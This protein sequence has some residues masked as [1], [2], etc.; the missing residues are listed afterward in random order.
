MLNKRAHTMNV[1]SLCS[2][3][4]R[5]PAILALHNIRIGARFE[6][7]LQES[8]ETLLRRNVQRGRA[9]LILLASHV[10]SKHD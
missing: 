8:G 10:F 9:I 5:R 1:W 3:V 7:Q 6:Q 4:E 2:Y